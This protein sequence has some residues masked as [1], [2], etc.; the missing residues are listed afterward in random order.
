MPWAILSAE[1]GVVRPDSVVHPYEKSADNFTRWE[2]REWAAGTALQ[3]FEWQRYIRCIAI[4][5]GDSYLT[6]LAA[7]LAALDVKVVNP[8]AGLGIGQQ[9]AFLRQATEAIR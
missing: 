3:I 5:A 2:R 8:C 7:T 6:P 9:M 4:I 1:Y